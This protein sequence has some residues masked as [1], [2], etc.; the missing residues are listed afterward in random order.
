VADFKTQ[1][2][3]GQATV[4]RWKDPRDWP[5][6]GSVEDHHELAKILSRRACSSLSGRDVLAWD[7]DPKGKFSVASG[8]AV[9]DKQLS[10]STENSW[11]KK[12]WNKFAWPKCNFFSWLVVQGKCLTWENLC[13]RGFQGPSMCVLCAGDEENISHLFFQCSFAKTIWHFW[14]SLW[15]MPCRHVLSL[16]DLW[17]GQGLP[18]VRT[19]FLLIAWAIGPSLIIWH[20][21]LER[22]R[23]IF[24]DR[25]LLVG[26]LWLRIL[27]GIQET[28]EAKCDLSVPVDTADLG[29]ISALG[30]SLGGKGI[31]KTTHH[32]SKR[33][34]VNRAGNWC[35]PA[36]GELKINTDGSSKGNPGHAGVG[37]IG[38]DSAGVVVFFFSIYRGRHTNNLMEATAILLALERACALGWRRIVCES[39]SQVVIDLLNRRQLEEVNWQLAVVVKQIV[40]LGNTLDSVVFCHVPREWNKVADCLARWASEQMGTWNMADWDNLPADLAMILEDLVMEDMRCFLGVS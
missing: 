12:V 28:L 26:Q 29:I 24:L 19:P 7:S 5:P 13:K 15:H 16:K 36:L 3:L 8:Y 39:D 38:R 30:L 6:D 31:V 25:K 40:A 20:I 23:R 11:W 37:G 22:N 2:I 17:D 27:G 4:S 18:S 9:L 14:W 10:G 32:G 21:W 35:P 33:E 34:K 1:Q